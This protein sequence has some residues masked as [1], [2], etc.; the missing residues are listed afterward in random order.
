MTSHTSEGATATGIP[1][2]VER[3]VTDYVADLEHTLPGLSA[4]VYLVGSAALE[5]FH[6]E[7]SD[8][9]VVTVL[10][11]ELDPLQ[12]TLLGDI[13][14]RIAKRH[15]PIR[16]DASY[17]T[18]AQLA[19]APS[20]RETAGVRALD[21]RIHV[22][23][24][25]SAPGILLWHQLHEQALTVVGADLRDRPIALRPEALQEWCLA[26]IEERWT[27]WWDRAAVLLSAGGRESLGAV[28]PTSGVLGVVRLHHTLVTGTLVSQC[29]AATWALTLCEPEWKRLLEECLRVRHHPQRPSLYR[30]PLQ[31]RRDALA[32]MDLLMTADE[33][34][35][36]GRSLDR[37]LPPE[38]R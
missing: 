34:A 21:G 24:D 33:E 13:H 1:D 5:D 25:T 12:L 2:D 7:T 4:G 16:L 9:D 11:D 19:Q 22:A 3:A 6:P 30:N 26:Q 32:F 18:W 14:A 36:G 17:L 10:E 35:F 20:S 28:G 29:Q 23:P 27:P 37:E 38:V 31:R 8:L 15:R